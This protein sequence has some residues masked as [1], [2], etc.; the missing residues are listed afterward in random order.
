VVDSTGKALRAQI[1]AIRPSYW[2][3]ERI[4]A[5]TPLEYDKNNI[6]RTTSSDREGRFR[7]E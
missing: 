7:L 3:G 2:A 6:S 5:E 4:L 1:Q